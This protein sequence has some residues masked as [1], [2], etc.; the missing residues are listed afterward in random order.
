M[1]DQNTG[2]EP[3]LMDHAKTITGLLSVE[4]EEPKKRETPPAGDAKPEPV[5]PKAEK[6]E[7]K[8][9]AKPEDVEDDDTPDETPDEPA[10]PNEVEDED[11]KPDETPVAR[12]HKVKVDGQELEVD[13]EELKKGYSRTQDYTRKTQAV[14]DERKKFEAEEVAPVRAERQ[15]YAERLNSLSEAIRSL[16]PD[17][18][19]DWEKVRATVSPAEYAEIHAS[20]QAQKG[21]LDRIRA[22][23]KR[24][25]DLQIADARK[26]LDARLADEESKLRQVMPEW[27]DPEEGKAFK[28][29]LV[30]HA[31]SL[32]F[33]EADLSGVIDHR[34]IVL[35][36][37]SRELAELKARKPKVDEKIDK[38]MDAIKP[39]GP[40]KAKK[41]TD[42][43]KAQRRLAKSGSVEDGAALISKLI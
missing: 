21:R 24:V 5:K 17:E 7:A 37:Q 35:L 8:P 26:Q 12:K 13:E 41:A 16:V 15:Q 11:E 6:P 33:T 10:D 18:E 9:A 1:N 3:T 22:E 4:A 27:A 14:A 38:A 2:P 31:K 25:Q 40:S 28:G 42:V 36:N 19:P 34:L 29:K 32:G 23:Q 30:A 39:S 43:E 20:F